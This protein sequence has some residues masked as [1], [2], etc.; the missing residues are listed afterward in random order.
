M[1]IILKNLSDYAM[2]FLDHN[3]FVLQKR[4]CLRLWLDTWV[5]SGESVYAPD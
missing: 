3:I 5:K 4:V 1:K 2:L